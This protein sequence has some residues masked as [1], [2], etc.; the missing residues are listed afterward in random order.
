[1]CES[2]S[3]RFH[4]VKASV[5]DGQ[6]DGVRLSML[7]LEVTVAI[8]FVKAPSPSFGPRVLKSPKRVPV[9]GLRPWRLSVGGCR[10]EAKTGTECCL[11]PTRTSSS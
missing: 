7:R 10:Y 9:Q 1:M 5:S 3:L 8:W 4:I 2:D 6:K 11:L